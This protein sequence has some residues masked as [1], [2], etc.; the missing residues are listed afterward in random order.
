MNAN[1]REFPSPVIPSAACAACVKGLRRLRQGRR[2]F[3]A[4]RMTA[5]KFSR[6]FAS[7]CGFFFLVVLLSGCAG[8]GDGVYLKPV[9]F[10]DLPGWAAD[11]VAAALPA[12]EKSC[13]VVLKK[14]PL[15]AFGAGGFAGTAGEW[16]AVCES[17]PEGDARAWVE[18]GFAPYALYG[19]AGPEGL[20]T[21]Y[22]EP[23]LRGSYK[24]KKPY[25]YPLYTRPE[26]LVTA[27]LG[28]FR[29]ELKGKTITGRVEKT[30]E[31]AKFVPYFTRAEIGKG[32]L[33]KEE[34]IVWVDDP[35]DAF[36]LHIQGSGI[37]KMADGTELRAGYA[38]QNGHPYTAIGRELVR[39]GALAR[40]NVSMQAIRAW[41]S[42][43][44]EEAEEV[45]NLNA[46]Y[47]FFRKLEGGAVGAQGV[48]LTPG[49]SLAVD[50]R[51]IPYGAPLF[52]DTADPDGAP[53]QRLMVAQDT[54]GAI[55]G[56][57][58]GDI[59]WGAGEEAADKA[60]RMKSK[61]RGYILLPKTVR[62]PAEKR[63]HFWRGLF[64]SSHGAGSANINK[65]PGYNR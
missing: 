60:G 47:V 40:E 7:L 18:A 27:D 21:G 25:L 45:M 8:Q 62:V 12:L 49:R 56:A 32:A 59:F 52:V 24:R 46:S 38:A 58:R 41:L 2:S 26:S 3:A 6:S 33:A 50:G 29:D 65:K 23:L 39:R 4:F 42:A 1:E 54:G 34:K 28:L 10:T 13:A 20:Y 53:F 63:W 14:D 35:V 9:A 57:V 11:D 43:H 5:G 16:R 15:A 22:Y 19:A 44:P 30:K 37:V 51:K 48:E 64:A 61:G 31:G 55:R 36:F 17:R